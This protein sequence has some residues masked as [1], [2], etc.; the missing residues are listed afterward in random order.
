ME[1]ISW[2]VLVKT[3][4]VFHGAK[5]KRDFPCT[6]K[7]RKVKWIGHFLSR[8]CLLRHVIEVNIEGWR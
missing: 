8:N 4:E 3:E 1:K 6:V 5:E 2:T 7:I